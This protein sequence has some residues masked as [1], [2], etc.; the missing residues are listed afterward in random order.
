MNILS[1]EEPSDDFVR[2]GVIER[3]I[4]GDTIRIQVDLGWTAKLREDIRLSFL[5]APESQGMY[6]HEHPAG[7]WVKDQVLNFIGDEKKIKIRSNSYVSGRF[8]RCICEAWVGG[9]QVNFFLLSNKLAWPCDDRGSI[10][11]ERDINSLTGIPKKI[12]D[13]VMDRMEYMED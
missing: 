4:D 9:K 5:N 8:G 1:A 3:V 10:I 7:L 13:E 12:R 6:W 2:G 11:G